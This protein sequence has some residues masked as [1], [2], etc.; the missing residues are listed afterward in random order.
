MC[1]GVEYEYEKTGFSPDEVH[2]ADFIKQKD[3]ITV[4]SFKNFVNNEV[5]RASCKF[6]KFRVLDY[7][8]DTNWLVVKNS[9][10]ILAVNVSPIEIILILSCKFFVSN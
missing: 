1:V 4:F 10:N 3:V 5:K 2:F 6:T 7:L 8:F 9:F